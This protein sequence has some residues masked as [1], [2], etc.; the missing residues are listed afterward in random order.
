MP[1]L[2]LWLGFHWDAGAEY[3]TT[4]VPLRSKLSNLKRVV[5]PSKLQGHHSPRSD[6]F[7]HRV[8]PAM[9]EVRIYRESGR[10]CPFEHPTRDLPPQAM[11]ACNLESRDSASNEACQH[12]ARPV[13]FLERSE[14]KYTVLF[15]TT[16][17]KTRTKE[18][19]LGAVLM[20]VAV[21][22]ECAFSEG[23]ANA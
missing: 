20:D 21:V 4:K 12:I 3:R 14:G 7:A 18:E 6:V 10:S 15:A 23:R 19:R 5:S 17:P 22:K 13:V 11:H 8:W 2:A 1:F 9:L 16:K